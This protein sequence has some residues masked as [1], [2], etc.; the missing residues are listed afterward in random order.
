MNYSHRGNDDN[1]GEWEIESEEDLDFYLYVK[2]S[3]IEKECKLC[4][5]KVQL[6]PHYDKCNSC[7][8]MIESGH[9]W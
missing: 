8:E 9:Q 4:G 6:L 2:E 1:F 7:C 5:N 3:S